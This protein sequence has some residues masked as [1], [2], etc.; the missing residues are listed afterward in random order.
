MRLKTSILLFSMKRWQDLANKFDLVRWI[1]LL[2]YVVA[3]LLKLHIH[4]INFRLFGLDLDPIVWK[5]RSFLGEK[6]RENY[7]WG[8]AVVASVASTSARFLSRFARSTE[9]F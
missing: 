1:R 4:G 2:Y 9:F 3:Q 5:K 6:K 7:N 8:T